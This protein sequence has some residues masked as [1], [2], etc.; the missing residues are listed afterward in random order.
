LGEEIVSVAV[1]EVL[2]GKEE[3]LIAMLRELYSMMRDKGY[4]RDIL[5][6]DSA[7]RDRFVHTRFWKSEQTRAEAQH[8]PEVHR[9]WLRLPELCTI[10]V[11]YESLE[12]V[13][14]T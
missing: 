14:E 5:R 7:R 12:T 1:I 3:E 4:S 13:F 11:I 2:P 10:P 9:Y 8:D 6:R